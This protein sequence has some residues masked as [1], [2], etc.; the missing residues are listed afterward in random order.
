M[1]LLDPVKPSSN[2]RAQ[3]LH[4]SSDLPL[5]RIHGIPASPALWKLLILLYALESMCPDFRTD[6]PVLP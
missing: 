1:G 2:L 4:L 6:T 5:A 3:D